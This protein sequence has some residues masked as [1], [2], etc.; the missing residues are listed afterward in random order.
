MQKVSG[1]TLIE[2][3]IVM[4]IIGILVAIAVPAYSSYVTNARRSDAKAA[5]MSA[6]QICERY[7]SLNGNYGD[8]SSTSTCI[9]TSDSV[10]SSVSTYY[11]ISLDPSSTKGPMTGITATPKGAQKGDCTLSITFTGTR[12]C[13]GNSW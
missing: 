13:G 4:A 3:L 5:L 1:F 8:T 6:A 12:T 7:Y 2:L 10:F 11:D 9:T